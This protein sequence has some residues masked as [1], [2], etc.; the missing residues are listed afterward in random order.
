MDPDILNMLKIATKRFGVNF[1]VKDLVPVQ[2]YSP[3]NID[4]FQR[5]LVDARLRPFL[6]MKIVNE[7]CHG[8]S[9]AKGCMPAYFDYNENDDYEELEIGPAI[10]K[11]ALRDEELFDE[12]LFKLGFGAVDVE[13]R[14]YSVFINKKGDVPK[15]KPSQQITTAK[16]VNIM[17]SP[18]PAL[19][20]TDSEAYVI[21]GSE[22]EKNVR[23]LLAYHK[24]MFDEFLA[25]HASNK[26]PFVPHETYIKWLMRLFPGRIRIRSIGHSPRR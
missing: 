7:L 1:P 25:D 22:M 20:L 17:I 18:E 3:K 15:P 19:I 2:L 10:E 4:S 23:G 8:A 12:T 24:K 13:C 5:F 11:R 14:F 21:E 26:T 16:D 9:F 6:K